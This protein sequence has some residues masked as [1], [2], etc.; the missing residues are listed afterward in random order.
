MG[1][2]FHMG[3]GFQEPKNQRSRSAAWSGS[4]KRRTNRPFQEFTTPYGASN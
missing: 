2:R 1:K 4:A 3:K